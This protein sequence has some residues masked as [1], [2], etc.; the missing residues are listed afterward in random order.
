METLYP[1]TAP[2]ETGFLDVGDGHQLYYERFGNPQGRPVIYLH[3]GPGGGCSFAEYRMF[4]P[5]HFDV[6]LFDQRGSGKSTPY[7]ATNA[8]SIESLVG[9]IEKFRQHLGVQQWHVCGGSW[10]SALAMSYAAAHP[11]RVERML[12]RG[13]FFAEHKGAIHITEAPH[14]TADKQTSFYQDYIDLIPEDERLRD[15]LTNAYAKR[16]KADDPAT[17]IEAARRFYVWD[18][19]IATWELKQDWIDDANKDPQSTLA[20]SKIWFHFVEN[21]FKDENRDRLLQA[22]SKLTVPVDIIHGA[23]DKICPV[24]N[25]YDLNRVCKNSTL[26]VPTSC[27]HSQA[28]PALLQ[29]F[30]EITNRWMVED[31]KK[32]IQADPQP[33]PILH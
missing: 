31:L 23:D 25:A 33:K 17:A 20:L 27:G 32:K 10:G 13:I 8:N 28:E 15:G 22:M 18:T 29:G 14:L 19:A 12:L 3:G 2:R 24:Q 16:L 7:A 21:H 6:L 4:H 26:L 11:D 1:E 30:I 5:D 9:D